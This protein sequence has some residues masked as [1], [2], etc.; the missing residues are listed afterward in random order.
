[1]ATVSMKRHRVR[2]VNVVLFVGSSNNT[3]TSTNEDGRRGRFWSS[4]ADAMA[5]PM[6]RLDWSRGEVAR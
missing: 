3:G 4:S 6:R 2:G 1:M 5:K